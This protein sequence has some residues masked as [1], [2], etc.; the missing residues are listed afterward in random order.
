MYAYA[1]LKEI[2]MNKFL[3]GIV[4]T[5]VA[6]VAVLPA[7]SVTSVKTANAASK[8]GFTE[9]KQVV[10]K[11]GKDGKNKTGK[12]VIMNWGAREEDCVFLSTYAE[13]FYTGNYTYEKL[14]ANSG[15]SAQNDAPSSNLYKALQSMMVNKH[16]HQTTYGETRYQYCYTDC[17]KNNS[18]TIS[19]FYSG[20]SL[21][22]TWDSG[23]T[24]NREHT[25]P[26]SKSLNGTQTSETGEEADIMM[27]RPAAV[28]ENGGRSN[29]AYGKSSGY[30]FPNEESNGSTDVRGDCARIF[31]YVYV[32]WGNNAGYAWG[33]NGVME[34]MEV[35]LEWMEADPVDTWEMG[36]NDS[37]QSITGTRNV[38]V[39]YPE[40]AWKLFGKSVPKVVTPSGLAMG[41]TTTP[42]N[43]PVNPDTPVNPPVNPPVNSEH[44]FSDWSIKEEPTATTDGIKRRTCFSCGLTEIVY[45]SLAGCEHTYSDWTK[46]PSGKESKICSTC[47]NTV[48]KPVAEEKKKDYTG[49]I[50]GVSIGGVAVIAIGVTLFILLKKKA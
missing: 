37:V 44:N 46:L 38:F 12:N 40:F 17:E 27:L 11:T 5:L 22:S 35:L 30:Y 19:S 20:K 10:Y 24:W 32:R 8:T 45:Y 49:V 9:A 28:S 18:S 47:G 14:A 48:I 4:A 50:V 16:S 33:K 41:N 31:L 43:P 13:S 21:S 23:S 39:D 36:R 2:F 42:E 29:T 1:P 3:K 15:G 6:F 25:W 34:S 26:K 7:S